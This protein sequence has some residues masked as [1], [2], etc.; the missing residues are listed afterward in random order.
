M[1]LGKTQNR[2]IPEGSDSPIGVLLSGGIDSSILLGH[3]LERGYRVRPFYIRSQL[4]W[5]AAE[6]AAA[7]RFLQAVAAPRLEKL[8]IL[9][10]PLGDLYEDHW[11]VTARHTPDAASDDEA[12]YLPGRNTLLIVK[13]AL[14]C[15][16]HGVEQLALGVLGCNPFADA[17][18]EFFES[19]QRALNCGTV[20]RI[21]IARP[22]AG[23]DKRQVMELG[24]GLPLEWTFSCI[25]PSGGLHCGQCNKCA[26]RMAAFRVVGAHDPTPYAVT[27]TS[28]S[29]AHLTVVHPGDPSQ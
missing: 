26:E 6:L 28:E 8:V 4:V 11:S 13:A 7:E 25:A 17:T 21:Q 1:D 22:F 20:A 9:D 27:A 23:F 29:S 3:L 19:L 16:L 24:R 2:M 5:Q 10:L 15:Q 14:W 12:V 18:P